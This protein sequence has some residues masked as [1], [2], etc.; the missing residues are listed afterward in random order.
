[1]PAVETIRAITL[2]N[3]GKLLAITETIET[4]NEQLAAIDAKI[5]A[6][7]EAQALEVDLTAARQKLSDIE[8]QILQLRESLG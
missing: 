4:L 6:I 3:R 5:S 8:L 2:D 7:Q 1:M